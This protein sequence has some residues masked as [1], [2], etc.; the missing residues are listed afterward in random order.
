MFRSWTRR[1][2]APLE[3]EE[4]CSNDFVIGSSCAVSAVSQN[5]RHRDASKSEYLQQGLLN[6][7]YDKGFDSD[8][9]HRSSPALE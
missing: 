1:L 3:S 2:A 8:Q 6:P 9:P 7:P 5:G 4:S